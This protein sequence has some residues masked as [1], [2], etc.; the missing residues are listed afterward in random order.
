MIPSWLGISV[1]SELTS[2][3]TRNDPY[4]IGPS[5][6]ILVMKSCVSLIYDL[7]VGTYFLICASTNLLILAVGCVTELHMGLPGMLILCILG[8]R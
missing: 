1:Y 8:S 7:V 5:S 4:G 6:F 2:S 3:V